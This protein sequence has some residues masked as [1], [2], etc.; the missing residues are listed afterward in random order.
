MQSTA[1]QAALLPRAWGMIFTFSMMGTYL[2]V[3][4]C[5]HHGPVDSDQEPVEQRSGPDGGVV[6]FEFGQ[7]FLVIHQRCGIAPQFARAIL[8]IKHIPGVYMLRRWE[9]RQ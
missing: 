3:Q 7:F 5:G 6:H 2:Q 9:H 1:S 8:N 4:I